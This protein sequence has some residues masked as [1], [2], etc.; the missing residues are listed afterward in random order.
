MLLRLNQEVAALKRQNITQT[1]RMYVTPMDLEL[2]RQQL[3]Q[4]QE[5]DQ[6]LVAIPK[7]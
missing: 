2:G 1:V 4:K 5:L 3:Q 7:P 6:K